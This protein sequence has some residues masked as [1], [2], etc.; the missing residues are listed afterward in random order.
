MPEVV[1]STPFFPGPDDDVQTGSSVTVSVRQ[2]DSISMT[3]DLAPAGV[4]VDVPGT[5]PAAGSVPTSLLG[6]REQRLHAGTARVYVSDPSRLPCEDGGACAG[7]EGWYFTME[8]AGQ[9]SAVFRTPM[10]WGSVGASEMDS[11]GQ[12]EVRVAVGTAV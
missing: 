7:W 4:P 9:G 11:R 10:R 1:L 5:G 3:F 12:L 2:C 6:V 8:S